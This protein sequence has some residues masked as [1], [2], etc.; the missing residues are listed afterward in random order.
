VLTFSKVDQTF[1]DL[2]R[3]EGVDDTQEIID[4]ALTL[5]HQLLCALISSCG[6]TDLVVLESHRVNREVSR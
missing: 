1:L 4:F 3:W 6:V 2:D 5:Y